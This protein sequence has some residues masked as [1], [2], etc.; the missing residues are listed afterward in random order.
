MKGKII[1]YINLKVTL[2][3]Y[4]SIQSSFKD[5]YRNGTQTF[6]FH[7][8]KIRPLDHLTSSSLQP[9]ALRHCRSAVLQIKFLLLEKDDS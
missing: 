7:L 9:S 3:N 5:S 8:C 6:Q 4:Y 2:F 1:Y